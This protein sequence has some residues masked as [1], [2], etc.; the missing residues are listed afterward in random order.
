MNS[1]CIQPR[2]SPSLLAFPK[3]N[4][5]HWKKPITTARHSLCLNF[6]LQ[7]IH[8]IAFRAVAEAISHM[9]RIHEWRPQNVILRLAKPS[10]RRSGIRNSF[11]CS[12]QLW[13]RDCRR[14]FLLFLM[15]M[16]SLPLSI[17]D[18]GNA[19]DR[20]LIFHGWMWCRRRL[21]ATSSL[22]W[23]NLI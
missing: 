5:L 2:I 17:L 18:V 1:K 7:K 23:E 4:F 16:S 11:G 15:M 21:V 3:P 13:S 10:S 12:P 8:T 22:L 14:K 20:D 6:I 9:M 19:L